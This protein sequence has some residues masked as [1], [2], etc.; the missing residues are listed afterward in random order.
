MSIK[1]ASYVAIEALVEMLVRLPDVH[2]F[3]VAS[4]IISQLSKGNVIRPSEFKFLSQSLSVHN[5]EFNSRNSLMNFNTNSD[6]SY[7]TRT[8]IPKLETRKKRKISF[9]IKSKI[10]NSSSKLEDNIS[11]SE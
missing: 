8:S 6:D 3:S 9:L 10:C 11:R 4:H 2:K 7:L 1:S 5:N